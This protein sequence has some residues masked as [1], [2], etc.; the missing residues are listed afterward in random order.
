MSAVC[1]CN[2]GEGNSGA[3]CIIFF[4]LN[5][6]AHMYMDDGDKFHKYQNPD[7]KTIFVPKSLC[8]KL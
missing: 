6:V 8:Y 1:N 4:L 7:G 2:D 3:E 5:M